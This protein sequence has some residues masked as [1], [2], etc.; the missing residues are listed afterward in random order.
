MFRR[1]LVPL[2]GS[3]RAERAI[4]VAARLARPVEGHI[5]LLRVVE[6]FPAYS[7]RFA[8]PVLPAPTL[9]ESDVASA[10]VYLQQIAASPVLHDIETETVVVEGAVAESILNAVAL[11]HIDLV[12][13]CSH[14]R[15]ALLR[16]TLGSV[17]EHVAHHAAVP[18][19]VLNAQGPVP[20]GPH[21][22]P[23]EILRVLVP[24]D[25]S[26]L[27]ESALAPATSLITEL[28]A[29]DHGAL[30]LT[31]VAP[32]YAAD[33]NNMP[34]ALFLEGAKAYLARVARDVRNDAPQLHVSWSIAVGYDI[35][36]E[37]LRVAENGEDAEGAGVFGGC[38]LIA[39]ATHGYSGISRL[40]LGSI[41]ERLLHTTKLPI[42]IV[43][44]P[45]IAAQGQAPVPMT[46]TAE[47]A[48]TE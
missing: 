36:V 41:A 8:M 39:L 24:L 17:A 48:H 46:S 10:S 44:P 21:P 1:I 12:V 42:L 25:G 4:A 19:F 18:V 5:V 28:A 35:A 9:S 16:W 32:P 33:K 14:G 6:L 38:D 27:A 7:P 20:A 47:D 29:P 40:A 31:L 34:D 43:R 22:D 23:E 3:A 2:D 30:H 45:Q 11:H 37:L 15:T 13:L 26:L